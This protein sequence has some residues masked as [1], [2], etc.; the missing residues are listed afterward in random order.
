MVIDNILKILLHC[1]LGT[2]KK[3]CLYI[4]N[5]LNRQV[6]DITS[7]GIVGIFRRIEIDTHRW[8]PWC[9]FVKFLIVLFVY[10][11]FGS[12]MFKLLDGRGFVY[13][14]FG[15]ILSMSTIGIKRKNNHKNFNFRILWF[16]AA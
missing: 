13:A 12:W 9:G 7:H 1:L 14:V 11:A 15:I 5:Y 3:G 10:I 4:K 8:H 6:T 2:I 16:F